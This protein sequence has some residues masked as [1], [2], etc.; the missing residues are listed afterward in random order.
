VRFFVVRGE[1]QRQRSAVVGGYR[2]NSAAAE[3]AELVRTAASWVAY[4]GAS[5]VAVVALM[6]VVRAFAVLPG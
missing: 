6:W 5:A 2:W 1:R 4:V 3:L